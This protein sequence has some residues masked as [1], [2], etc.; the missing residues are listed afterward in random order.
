MAHS[1]AN[2]F[3]KAR[4]LEEIQQKEVAPLKKSLGQWHWLE[5][6]SWREESGGVP[7]P[8]KRRARRIH[9][10]GGRREGGALLNDI[11]RLR[12]WWP[13]HVVGLPGRTQVG[14]EVEIVFL[15]L[16]IIEEIHTGR[17]AVRQSKVPLGQALRSRFRSSARRGVSHAA[18]A[19]DT[20]ETTPGDRRAAC[21]SLVTDPQRI[22]TRQ[23]SNKVEGA[24]LQ[25]IDWSSPSRATDPQ[26]IVGPP[27]EHQSSDAWWMFLCVNSNESIISS[28]SSVNVLWDPGLDPFHCKEGNEILGSMVR[29][30]LLEMKEALKLRERIAEIYAQRTGNPTSIISRDMDRDVFFSA[31]Q[32]RIYGI[33]DDIEFSDDEE[34]LRG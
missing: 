18:A 5:R 22:V 31:R 9:R 2:L 1:V 19:S 12:W 21:L 23:R 24:V 3:V 6:V 16:L 8:W 33:I 11:D 17:S 30:L 10:S 25:S 4:E 29:E 13:D 14:L 27:I 15:S 7:L 34:F 28:M 26:R 32:A 20:G